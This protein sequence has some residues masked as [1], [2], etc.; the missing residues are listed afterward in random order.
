MTSLP[1]LTVVERPGPTSAYLFDNAKADARGN[2]TNDPD[3]VKDWPYKGTNH[4]LTLWDSG[5]RS[6]D[7][8]YNCTAAC[9][10][11][12]V[13]PQMT[14]NLRGNMTTLQNCLIYPILSQASENGWLTEEPS[15]LL[16][17]YKIVV[18]NA[19]QTNN[20]QNELQGASQWPVINNRMQRMCQLVYSEGDHYCNVWGRYQTNFTTAHGNGL[21][22]SLVGM[23]RSQYD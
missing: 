3:A 19:S 22:P 1:H 11:T 23:K 20:S 12:T 15:G 18:N 10:D 2:T 13:G 7:G 8:S 4:T 9:K 21:W 6:I 17:K 14:W 16:G 5:C